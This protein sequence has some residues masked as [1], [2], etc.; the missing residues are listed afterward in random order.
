MSSQVITT[1]IVAE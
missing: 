1:G